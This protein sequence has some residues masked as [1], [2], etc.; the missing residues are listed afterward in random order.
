MTASNTAT[1][2]AVVHALQESNEHRKFLQMSA[3]D[4]SL[5]DSEVVVAYKA[6][7]KL[8][9]ANAV[10]GPATPV[11]AIANSSNA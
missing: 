7:Q 6:K 9:I 5:T 11:P 3:V 10:A 2:S 1:G 8:A 4:F